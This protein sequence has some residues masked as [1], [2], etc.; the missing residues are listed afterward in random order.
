MIAGVDDI[1]RIAC[2]VLLRQK[3]SKVPI[4]LTE[5]ERFAIAISHGIR[6]HVEID[7]ESLRATT[8]PCGVSWT[9]EKFLVVARMRGTEA[10]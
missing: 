6:F 4:K 2:D 7:G 10:A 5:E 8:E 1:A 3:Q 9:G